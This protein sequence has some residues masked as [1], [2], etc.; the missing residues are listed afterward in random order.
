MLSRIE[1]RVNLLGGGLQR[2]RRVAA[3]QLNLPQSV[4]VEDIQ[5]WSAPVQRLTTPQIATTTGQVMA[6][7]GV[8]GCK[9][10][11]GSMERTSFLELAARFFEGPETPSSTSDDGVLRVRRN[12]NFVNCKKRA[13]LEH[14]LQADRLLV[15]C[16]M[17]SWLSRSP[18]TLKD[19]KRY[20]Y[21]SR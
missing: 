18:A 12:V 2:D 5:H 21:H 16:Y 11:V 14:R 19:S 10:C 9:F 4:Y 15:S 13:S 6:G 7:Y 20:T 1:F 3:I 17:Q 8:H